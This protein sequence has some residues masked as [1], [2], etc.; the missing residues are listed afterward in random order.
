MRYFDITDESKELIRDAEH[1]KPCGDVA[2]LVKTVESLRRQIE[3]MDA[4]IIG[5]A[6]G[7]RNDKNS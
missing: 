5:F 7:G 6:L 3:D 4:I 2:Y 1:R